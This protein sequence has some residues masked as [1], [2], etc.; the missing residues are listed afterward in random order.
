MVYFVVVDSYYGEARIYRSIESWVLDYMKTFNEK[1]HGN[2]DDLINDL[3][4]KNG[5]VWAKSFVDP[6]HQKCEFS[7]KEELLR[8]FKNLPYKAE[9]ID[10]SE[11]LG[12]FDPDWLYYEAT[13]IN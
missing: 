1:H 10:V 6:K 7:G 11:F 13:L 9:L 3:S 4:N 2:L 8:A 12:L 5:P